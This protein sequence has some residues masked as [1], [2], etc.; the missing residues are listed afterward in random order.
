MR[1]ARA[2]GRL[3]A[4]RRRRHGHPWAGRR[5][6]SRGAAR[7][8]PAHPPPP[9]PHP[10]PDV[11][12]ALLPAGLLDHDLG[13]RLARGIARGPHRPLHLGPPLP[14]RGQGAALRRLLPRHARQR[15]GDRPGQDPCRVR[16][17]PRP[18]PRVQDHRR[19]HLARL[20]LRPRAGPGRAARVPRARVDLGPR[21]RLRGRPADPRLPVHRR[22]VPRPRRLGP[23]PPHRRPHLRA[24]RGGPQIDALP[25]RPPP[26][27]RLPG[28]FPR[29]GDGALGRAGRQAGLH[30]DGNRASASW[31]SRRRRSLPRRRRRL[32]RSASAPPRAARPR[33]ARPATAA[34]PRRCAVPPAARQA[35]TRRR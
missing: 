2:L 30:R 21:A 18:D 29:H 3:D 32:R 19:R 14:R 5:D 27:R 11:L 1:G 12:R 34:W 7:Q 28:R 23:L 9:R 20:H 6:R 31:R 35:A 10:G 25:P 24:P 15:V 33:A 26:L 16:H 13:T 22:G 8:H 4:D 17:P